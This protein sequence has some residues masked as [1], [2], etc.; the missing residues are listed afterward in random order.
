MVEGASW[1][2]AVENNS[3]SE[4]PDILRS[5]QVHEG[6]AARPH[7]GPGLQALWARR[8]L[9]ARYCWSWHIVAQD[10]EAKRTNNPLAAATPL[11]CIIINLPLQIA[12]SCAWR[13]EGMSFLTACVGH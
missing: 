13:S 10:P 11:L 1:L 8:A 4:S 2:A 3:A 7:G 9:S 6:Y 5:R 12:D